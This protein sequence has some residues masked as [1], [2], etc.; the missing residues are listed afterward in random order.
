MVQ[1]MDIAQHGFRRRG[2]G[3]SIE[4]GLIGFRSNIELKVGSSA[5]DR[6]DGSQSE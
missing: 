1:T 2:P 6:K 5:S 3:T 4:E